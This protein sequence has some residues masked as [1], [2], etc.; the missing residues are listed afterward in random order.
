MERSN[1]K[2]SSQRQVCK[3][4]NENR[5]VAASYIKCFAIIHS[6]H[7]A[8]GS[9]ACA[10]SSGVVGNG[11]GGRGGAHK[12]A[13]QLDCDLFLMV[14]YERRQSMEWPLEQRD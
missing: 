5:S 12:F 1:E 13:V 8:S 10:P 14:K 9:H 7:I 6:H 11:G 3:I 2:K 4:A